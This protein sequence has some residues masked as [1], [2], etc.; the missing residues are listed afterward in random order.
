MNGEAAAGL[1]PGPAADHDRHIPIEAVE[2]H[3]QAGQRETGVTAVEKGGDIGLSNAEPLGCRSLTELLPLENLVEL[4]G[5][6]RLGL[7]LVSVLEAEVL[8]DVAAAF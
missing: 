2:K 6:L 5:Q 8:E 1:R 3:H 4:P 7:E